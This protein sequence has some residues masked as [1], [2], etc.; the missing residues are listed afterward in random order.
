MHTH[1]GFILEI[2]ARV[3]KMARRAKK[4]ER[5]PRIDWHR[6]VGYLEIHRL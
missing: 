1:S 6:V 5:S 3:D 4:M 2:I